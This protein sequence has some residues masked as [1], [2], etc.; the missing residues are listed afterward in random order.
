MASVSAAL[1]TALPARSVAVVTGVQIIAVVVAAVRTEPLAT[2]PT[3][4]TTC[5]PLS[6]AVPAS[7]APAVVLSAFSWRSPA[8]ASCVVFAASQIDSLS[9]EP[10]PVTRTLTLIAAPFQPAR[11]EPAAIASE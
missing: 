3:V 1:E 6:T 8:I 7:R 11:I 4:T 10:E 2:A 5:E 9:F